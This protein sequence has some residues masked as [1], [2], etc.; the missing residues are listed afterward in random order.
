VA[1]KSA[2]S[3]VAAASETTRPVPTLQAG[4]S[5]GYE[6]IG[7][8]RYSVFQ[9]IA[10]DRYQGCQAKSIGNA[11]M[12]MTTWSFGE[13]WPGVYRANKLVYVDLS[14]MA[15]KLF[16]KATDACSKR[17]AVSC[18]V[19]CSATMIATAH[20]DHIGCGSAPLLSMDLAVGDAQILR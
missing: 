5:D 3:L 2:Y 20:C 18:R 4:A 14:D 16:F 7:V 6:Y 8:F 12:P 13:N 19:R 1:A 10:A 17:R 15:K 11:L 9:A